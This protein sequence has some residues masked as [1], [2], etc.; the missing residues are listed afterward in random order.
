MNLVEFITIHQEAGTIEY[1]RQG[2][3]R[4]QFISPMPELA[5]L[6]KVILSKLLKDSDRQKIYNQL[7][8]GGL[9]TNISAQSKTDTGKRQSFC[10]EFSIMINNIV[11]LLGFELSKYLMLLFG[12][13]HFMNKILKEINTCT[14]YEDIGTYIN[15]LRN[16]FLLGT[17]NTTTSNPI[18]LNTDFD[19]TKYSSILNGSIPIKGGVNYFNMNVNITPGEAIFTWMLKYIDSH[20]KNENVISF[21][22]DR[23]MFYGIIADMIDHLQLNTY[24]VTDVN[25][26]IINLGRFNVCYDKSFIKMFELLYQEG[27]SDIPP[28]LRRNYK[29]HV[30]YVENDLD[31]E[32]KCDK[33]LIALNKYFRDIYDNTL[34]CVMETMG[35]EYLTI[36]VSDD[37][38]DMLANITLN[39]FVCMCRKIYNNQ[40]IY[41]FFGKSTR[42]QFIQVFQ[43]F[44]DC[45]PRYYTL[46]KSQ[47]TVV[48][49]I[50]LSDKIISESIDSV[51][52]FN[53]I[54]VTESKVPD[55]ENENENGDNCEESVTEAEVQPVKNT[56]RSLSKV[57]GSNTSKTVPKTTPKITPTKRGTR[58]TQVQPS[59]EDQPVQITVGGRRRLTRPP[60][61]TRPTDSRDSPSIESEE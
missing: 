60:T 4:S 11:G 26:L 31:H 6:M 41:G 28:E 38:Y 24:V 52:R 25:E 22:E 30:V 27:F 51:N 2:Y 33:H 19:M 10:A 14:T 5:Q 44:M 53:G 1:I 17:N 47:R 48:H 58:V 37:V 23:S 12:I 32:I 46:S 8:S 29:P 18:G 16:I 34:K 15:Y 36:D 45:V 57:V 59:E 13:K 61:A 50:L 42:I 9:P 56:R 40:L 7:Q 49:Y 54:E 20:I 35:N 21:N 3:Q 43:A 39:L 55:E